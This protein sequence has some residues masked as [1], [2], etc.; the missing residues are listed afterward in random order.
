MVDQLGLVSLLRQNL[1][2]PVLQAVDLKHRNLHQRWV[3]VKL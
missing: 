1:K 2:V 3:L